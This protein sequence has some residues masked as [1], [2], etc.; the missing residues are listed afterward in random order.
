MAAVIVVICAV[1][2]CVIGS[3]SLDQTSI[4]ARVERLLGEMNQEEKLSLLTGTGF[5]TRAI[6]RLGIPP[7]AMADAGQ[8]V[9]GGE[10]RTL[11]PATAFPSAVAMAATWDFDL[12]TRIGAAIGEEAR[13]KKTGI[14]MMLGPAVNIQR[15][16][17]GGRDGEYFSEDP[18]LAGRAAVAFIRG[19]Q[20]TGV[21]SCIKHF[22][23]NNE[24][25]D[26]TDVNVRVGERRFAG[27][28]SPRL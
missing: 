17:L 5:A 25:D 24:E 19:M 20:E 22:A 26:R 10:D 16:P 18:Y 21:G 2:S 3:D 14:Q 15:S 23:C 27:D 11:G 13:N 1:H 12:L 28:L 8:G 7:M 6:P 9:R 4:E